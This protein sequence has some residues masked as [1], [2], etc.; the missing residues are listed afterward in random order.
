MTD[1]T[2]TV[3]PTFPAGAVPSPRPVPAP[4]TATLITEQQV[5]FG[6]AVAVALPRV[7]RGRWM[8]A[9]KALS[10]TW[11]AVFAD[12][13]PPAQRYKA[14]RYAYLEDSMMSREMTRL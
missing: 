13:R 8:M 3:R 5:M 4:S 1:L 6:T 12:S 2:T 11:S 14:G 9:I 10:D 7:R